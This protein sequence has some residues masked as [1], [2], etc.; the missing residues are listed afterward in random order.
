MKNKSLILIVCLVLLVFGFTTAIAEG[1]ETVTT[2]TCKPGSLLSDDTTL[3]QICETAAIR[4]HSMPEGY[5][6][7]SLMFNDVDTLQS[8]FRFVENGFYVQSNALG[9]TPLYF[10]WDDLMELAMEQ[11]E[12][13]PEL[14]EMSGMFNPATLQS[15]LDGSMTDSQALD[16][17]GVDQAMLD[18][19]SEV[20]ALETVETGSFTLDGSDVA[21]Q[22]S[23]IV[24][25]KDELMKAVDLP[26]VYNQISSQLRMSSPSLTEEEVAAEVQAQLD[27]V[28]QSLEE[29][30][31]AVTVTKYTKDEMFVAFE[32]VVSGSMDN[33]DDSTSNMGVTVKLTKTTVEQAEFYQLSVLFNE[34]DNEILNQSGSLYLG[35]DFVTGNYLINTMDGESIVSIALGFDTSQADR[36][37]GELSFTVDDTYSGSSNTA[38]VIFD[39]AIAGNTTDTVISLFAG[40]GD[41]TGIKAALGQTDLLSLRFTTVTQPDSGFF[42]DLQSAAPETSVQLAQM[43][44]DELNAYMEGMQQSLM[45]TVLTLIDNLPP[46]ISD[47]LMQGMGS[48]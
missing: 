14:G 7:F 19:I 22:K 9:T 30:N 37:T 48:Y 36:K 45:M 44:E 13:N 20:E 43:T 16:M 24:L 25:T 40:A 2:I 38:L 33:Y 8:L 26:F 21:D 3:T 17:M 6:S 32:L 1:T 27:E 39:Q 18:Y 15:M 29:A 10:S 34:G 47:S 11:L 46:D 41:A 4:I 5:G 31:V 42:S 23:V 28:K 35:D 12:N